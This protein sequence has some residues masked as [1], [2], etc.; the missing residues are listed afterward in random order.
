MSKERL[1]WIANGFIDKAL[2]APFTVKTDL[3]YRGDLQKK[4]ELLYSKAKSANADQESLDIINKYSNVVIET[5][6]AYYKGEISNA[7]GKIK[8]LIKD[9]MQ[10]PFAVNTV[11]ASAA[12]PGIK[13]TEIQFFRARVSHEPKG[14]SAKEMLHLP[15]TMRGKTGSYRFSIPGVPSLYLGNTSYAC[16]IEMGRPAE[17]DFNVSPVLLDNSQK[18]FNLAVL[19]R[20]VFELH[21]LEKSC[22]HCWLKL[23]ILMFATSY[24]VEEKGR[25]F[26][27]EYIVSQSI[28]LI[29]KEL[30]LD[31]V[32]YFSKRVDDEIFALAAIN[33]ALFAPYKN[34][35]EYSELCEHIKIDD[36]FNYALFKQLGAVPRHGEYEM[37]VTGTGLVTN[38]GSYKR[39]YAYTDTE[40]FAFD[41]FMFYSWKEKED[42]SWGNALE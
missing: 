20:R 27:S 9:C 12:F 33:V 21:D 26:K 36:S 1:T 7:H 14:F 29:C 13:G 15:I 19:T 32:A 10:H 23:L 34:N 37:R 6:D 8:E 38:I 11:D 35:V 4:Y 5:I 39:Q 30:G 18:V 2:Y 41:K 40:F 31:G 25:I 24:V 22:V 3:E 42:I 28:M 17:H 16:W